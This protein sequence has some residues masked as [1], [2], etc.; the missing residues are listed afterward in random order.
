METWK[1]AQNMQVVSLAEGA[2][3]GRLDDFQ[4]DLESRMIYG[5]RLKGVGMFAK[6]GGVPSAKLRLIGRD[7]CFIESDGDVEWTG[8]RANT[9][10]GRAWAS[11]YHGMSVMSR[12][13][14]MLGGVRDFVIDVTGNQVISLILHGNRLLVLDDE[15]QTGPDVIIVH[16]EDL[17]VQ[18][19]EEEQKEPWWARVRDAMRKRGTKAI[20]AAEP[21]E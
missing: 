13:G 20:E 10:E 21:A 6:A 16:T 12:R 11:S 2:S 17:I 9:V 14:A 19:P 1:R 3:V 8:G 15:V 18:L 4:F 5:W 7:V